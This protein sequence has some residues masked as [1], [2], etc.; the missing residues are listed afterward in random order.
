M[1]SPSKALHSLLAS[2]ER[3]FISTL[4]RSERF[5]RRLRSGPP[6]DSAHPDAR[7]VREAIMKN[8][9]ILLLALPVALAGQEAPPDLVALIADTRA[10]DV[11]AC[12]LENARWGGYDTRIYVE[13][14]SDAKPYIIELSK[15]ELAARIAETK[16]DWVRF[17][18]PLWEQRD[19]KVIQS[20][21]EQAFGKGVSLYLTAELEAPDS[22]RVTVVSNPAKPID[23]A[24]LFTAWDDSTGAGT[25]KGQ[26]FQPAAGAPQTLTVLEEGFKS[27]TS[28]LVYAKRGTPNEMNPLD[29]PYC[30]ISNEVEVKK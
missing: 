16:P 30:L 4:G 9:L 22:L 17:W 27:A 26:A 19:G 7:V 11:V 14:T 28:I 6:R 12:E 13:Q 29:L 2:G 15:G 24:T 23:N 1:A 10:R 21:A 5:E 18:M 25:L 3:E 8:F 20:S